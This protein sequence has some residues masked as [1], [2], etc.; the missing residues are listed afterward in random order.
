MELGTRG[1]ALPYRRLPIHSLIAEHAEAVDLPIDFE[2]AV[3][4]SLLVVA[5]QSAIPRRVSAR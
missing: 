4:V 3:P 1:G 2:E 5:S